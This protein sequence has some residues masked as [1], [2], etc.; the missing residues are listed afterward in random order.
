MRESYL[1]KYGAAKNWERWLYQRDSDGFETEPAVQIEHPIKMWMV[2]KNRSYD[3]IARSG[4]R[5]GLAIDDR[6]CGGKPVDVA[7]KI[8]YF[9]IGKGKVQMSAGRQKRTI[10][11]TGS[12]KLKTATYFLKNAV[13]S[14]K[15]MEYDIVFRGLEVEAVI[16][17]VRVIRVGEV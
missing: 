6:W 1:R 15:N 13:F 5:I 17:F 7:I 2:E 10:K 4:K 8:T 3:Y 16:S 14:A 12:G 9:D 11:L